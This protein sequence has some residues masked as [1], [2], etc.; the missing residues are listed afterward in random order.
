MLI[1]LMNNE[2]RYTSLC[3]AQIKR[4]D[5]PLER[6]PQRLLGESEPKHARIRRTRGVGCIIDKVERRAKME[7][8]LQEWSNKVTERSETKA[9]SINIQCTESKT[10]SKLLV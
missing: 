7:R 3:R 5:V 1:H 10:R 4:E 2:E 6:R 8:E 9:T